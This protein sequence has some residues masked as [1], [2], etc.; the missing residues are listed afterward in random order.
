MHT[1]LVD[2]EEFIFPG[3]WWFFLDQIDTSIDEG[4]KDTKGSQKLLKFSLSIHHEITTA[5]AFKCWTIKT[6][7]SNQIAVVMLPLRL[8]IITSPIALLPS[9]ERDPSSG[10]LLQVP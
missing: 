2:Q 8:H 3:S 5:T 4:Q 1:T 10:F 9:L 6:R 7:D